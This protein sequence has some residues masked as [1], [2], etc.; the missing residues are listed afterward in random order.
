MVCK[1]SFGWCL[2][3][4]L[5]VAVTPDDGAVFRCCSAVM[6]G[7]YY[8]QFIN[9]TVSMHIVTKETST[10]F[11][12]NNIKWPNRSSDSNS[13]STHEKITLTESNRMKW[14]KMATFRGRKYNRK[15]VANKCREHVFIATKYTTFWPKRIQ[16]LDFKYY[17]HTPRQ[18]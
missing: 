1:N 3:S 17:V 16:F 6:S 13:N 7:K 14:R 10:T 12:S 9:D 4:R 8:L 18:H 11:L 15:K 5:F 2:S